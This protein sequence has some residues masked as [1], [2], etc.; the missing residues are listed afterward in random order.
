MSLRFNFK[1]IDQNCVATSAKVT[2]AMELN[3]APAPPVELFVLLDEL[4]D[5]LFPGVGGFGVE[6]FG[7]V[8]LLEELFPPG[9]ELLLELF[10]AMCGASM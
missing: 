1:G 8:E 4:L 9:V 2:A 7:L 3:R 6:L 5:E 10:G